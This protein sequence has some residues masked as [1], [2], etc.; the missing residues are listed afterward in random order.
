MKKML[1]LILLFF[2]KSAFAQQHSC[3]EN[4]WDFQKAEN[5]N[6]D[7]YA[8]HIRYKIL[9]DTAL[10]GLRPDGVQGDL[11]TTIP[12][13]V[14][15]LH[16]PNEAIG[17]GRN[18][19]KAKIQEQIDILNDAFAGK[20]KKGTPDSGIKFCLAKFNPYY[21]PTSGIVRVA[22]NENFTT[23]QGIHVFHKIVDV[24]I[25][26]TSKA[27]NPQ[28]YLNI[29][30]TDIN[31]GSGSLYGYA[32]FP[33][34]GVSGIGN[35]PIDKDNPSGGDGMVLNCNYVGNSGTVSNQGKTAVHEMGHYFGLWHTFFLQPEQSTACTEV[36]CTFFGD[37]VCDTPPHNEGTFRRRQCDTAMVCRGNAFSQKIIST[38]NFMGYHEDDG[39]LKEFTFGQIVR[40]WYYIKYVR[41]GFWPDGGGR[42]DDSPVAGGRTEGCTTCETC[43]PITPKIIGNDIACDGE[44]VTYKL[45]AAEPYG[46]D[47]FWQVRGGTFIDYNGALGITIPYG[48]LLFVDSIRVK[49]NNIGTVHELLAVANRCDNVDAQSLGT[50]AT[51]TV[52]IRPFKPLLSKI[53]LPLCLAGVPVF[54]RRL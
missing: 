27:W 2:V 6:L 24:K 11:T 40:M 17:Q 31:D 46:C 25:K 49:W 33:P 26:N 1:I 12:V 45:D 38:Q 37:E 18:L 28:K 9:T 7:L 13:V 22:T 43:K 32:S 35:H 42:G 19:S 5:T 30:I 3:G 21:F 51:K 41:K 36:N 34:G 54:L 4:Y 8:Q 23:T 52:T 15:V 16:K 20:L 29:W 44:I 53:L 10:F 14:H 48:T 50:I 39:C 47:V